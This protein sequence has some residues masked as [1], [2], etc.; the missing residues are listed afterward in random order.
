MHLYFG[1][2]LMLDN[3]T[4]TSADLKAKKSNILDIYDADYTRIDN[5]VTEARRELYADIKKKM[6]V[7]WPGYDSGELDTKIETIRDYTNE[8]YLKTRLIYLTIANIYEHNDLIN[9]AA[10]YRQLADGVDLQ[11]YFDSDESETPSEDEQAIYP[12]ITFGR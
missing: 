5:A 12:G 3:I 4:I 2:F 8:Q 10:Y 9:E 11:F 6:T 7:D 1:I